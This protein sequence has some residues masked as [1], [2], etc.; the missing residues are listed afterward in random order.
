LRRSAEVGSGKLLSGI[1]ETS[2]G[3]AAVGNQDKSI[4]EARTERKMRSARAR[5]QIMGAVLL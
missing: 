4:G 3:V 2:F 5:F 1:S